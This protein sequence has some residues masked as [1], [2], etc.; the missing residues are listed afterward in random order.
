MVKYFIGGKEYAPGDYA[1]KRPGADR[2]ADRYIADMEK[3][4]GRM[5]RSFS[6]VNIPPSVC[7]SRKIGVGALEIA[8][9]VAEETGLRVVDREILEHI[10]TSGELVQKTV[11]AFEGKQPGRL[12]EFLSAIYGEKSFAE[13]EYA[14]QLFSTVFSLA[15]MGSTI[16][17]GRGTHLMLPRE[18]VLAVRVIA[19]DSF[20]VKRLAEALS[21]D[22]QA[23]AEKL[24][25]IDGE[26][27]E[28]FR[29]IFRLEAASPY[30]FDLV[31]NR[32]HLRPPALAAR[33]VSTAF[34]QKFGLASSGG[35][36][37]PKS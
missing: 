30:E 31:I 33:L 29:K 25:Q 22:E 28:Y 36:G 6:Q 12:R 21:V 19:S 2:L 15:G 13:N 26:Q 7:F 10:A 27:D 32:D 18:R 34:R 5:R 17:V 1:K 20:R 8:D 37:E 11:E 3:S 4:P 35:V 14:R 16:F 24:A 9:I 23:A